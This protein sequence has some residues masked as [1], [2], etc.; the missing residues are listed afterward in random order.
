MA[1]IQKRKKAN[2]EYSYRVRIR[3]EGAPLVTETFL[4]R[5]E[6]LA[7]GSPNTHASQAQLQFHVLTEFSNQSDR[8]AKS[9]SVLI[10]L[11]MWQQMAH[12]SGLNPNRVKDVIRCWCQPSL[13]NCFLE[14]QGDEYKLA[15]Y[16]ERAQKFLEIQGKRRIENS[17][18]GKRS[19]EKRREKSKKS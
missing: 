18:R 19:V 2:G 3:V 15:N 7:Q 13:I 14:K 4:T 1:S 12:D 11:A 17:E 10:P 5:K 9:G 8:L 16:Y 6:A